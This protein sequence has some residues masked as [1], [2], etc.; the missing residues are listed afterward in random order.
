MLT[1]LHRRVTA[2]YSRFSF[3]YLDVWKFISIQFV[4]PN[5]VAVTYIWGVAKGREA[6]WVENA[7]SSSVRG[8]GDEMEESGTERKEKEVERKAKEENERVQ[9]TRRKGRRI[10][11]LR[12]SE[13]RKNGGSRRAELG[14]RGISP[15]LWSVLFFILRAQASAVFMAVI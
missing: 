2:L 7:S 14:G 12:K 15:R 5:A 11:E 13:A 1:Q 9:G 10:E 8:I 6:G 4:I 3:L